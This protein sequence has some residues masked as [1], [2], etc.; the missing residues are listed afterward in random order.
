MN[1][2]GTV[3]HGKKQGRLLGYPTANV[4]FGDVSSGLEGVFAGKTRVDGIWL[5][6]AVFI[7]P[8]KS[9]S[10]HGA[11]PNK[12]QSDHG[13]RPNKSQNDHGAGPD[14]SQGD[15]G[16][17]PDKPLLEA[18]ILDFE[19]DLYGKRIDVQ[20]LEK[21][22]ESAKFDSVEALKK[23]IALDIKRIRRLLR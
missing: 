20:I 2:S 22:R 13:A 18:H 9:Q 6:S 23:Q 1:I 21:V 12:S 19:G 5:L 14:K 16:A 17:G 10:D 3:I 15:H 8:V 7:H 4:E 11:G